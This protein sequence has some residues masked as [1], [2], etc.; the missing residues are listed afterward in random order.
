[1]QLPRI[2]K[3]SL[4]YTGLPFPLRDSGLMIWKPLSR[5]AQHPVL[6]CH[7]PRSLRSIPSPSP[8][9]SSTLPTSEPGSHT[10][11]TEDASLQT[12]SVTDSDMA[13]LRRTEAVLHSLHACH[14]VFL[15]QTLREQYASLLWS[16]GTLASPSPADL[17][18][19]PG[20]W[21]HR[22][23]PSPAAHTP[24]FL[25]LH[26]GKKIPARLP[27]SHTPATLTVLSSCT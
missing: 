6:P 16:A 26:Q 10:T 2:C 12:W 4:V 1:M 27:P 24:P 13:N 11:E 18:G 21:G 5:G 23:G 22:E 19:E 15:T 8:S 20:C 17:G 7:F 25:T 3:P 14:M 9:P